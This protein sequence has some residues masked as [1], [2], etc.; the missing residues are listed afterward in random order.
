MRSCRLRPSRHLFTAASL[1][2]GMLAT[3]PLAAQQTAPGNEPACF[4][5][6]FG[7]WT[8][9]LDWKKAGHPP[10]SS[11]ADPTAPNNRQWAVTA[12]D[13]GDSLFVLFPS[14][15]PAGVL[16]KVRHTPA[17]SG[18]TVAAVATALVADGR[19]K[20]PATPA[21]VWAVPCGGAPG[22]ARRP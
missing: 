12:A 8:P 21:R 11:A 16:V 13:R 6:A 19:L 2:A 18:D 10:R 7:V 5:F 15:W 4:G 3:H 14:W 9:A 22:G 1:V 17:A 20:A